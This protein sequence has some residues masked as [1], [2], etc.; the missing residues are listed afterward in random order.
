MLLIDILAGLFIA[1]LFSHLWL[2]FIRFIDYLLDYQSIFWKIRFNYVFR[3]SNF[4]TKRHL[5]EQLDFAKDN[6][7]GISIMNTAYIYAYNQNF[8]IKR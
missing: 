7:D 1:A 5:L 6:E 3:N 8:K 2:N 4:S